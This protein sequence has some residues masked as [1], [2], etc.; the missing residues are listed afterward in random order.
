[1]NISVIKYQ[2]VAQI[3]FVDADTDYTRVVEY[4]HITGQDCNSTTISYEYPRKN[5]EPYYPIPNDDNH[6]L[7]KKYFL[8]ASK[9]KNA[10]FCGRL[11]EYQ[12]YNMDQVIARAL[13]IFNK[14]I[15]ND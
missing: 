1:M 3:N 5:G 14:Y 13:N 4:K 7:Y 9:L 2:K 8:E 15:K 6:I 12:Y 11:A 10:M